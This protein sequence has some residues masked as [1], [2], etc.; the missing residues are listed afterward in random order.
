M[1]KQLQSRQSEGLTR[2]YAPTASLP[3]LCRS[4]TKHQTTTPPPRSRGIGGSTTNS[5]KNKQKTGTVNLS[6]ALASRRQRTHDNQI[7]CID[8]V[9]AFIVCCVGCCLCCIACL[10][11]CCCYCQG[12]CCGWCCCVADI[13][14]GR[15][16]AV[17]AV[18][19][20]RR[21]SIPAH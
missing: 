15:V 13:A 10:L 1:I 20:D 8:V 2:G 9:A 17:V 16:V 21:I 14:T 12:S 11:A 5:N 6:A 7:K 3:P 18:V 4:T 19:D